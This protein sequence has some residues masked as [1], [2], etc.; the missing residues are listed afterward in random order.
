MAS[1]VA[2][3]ISNPVIE[4]SKWSKFV[5]KNGVEICALPARH[6]GG[7]FVLPVRY[8]NC[9]GYAITQGG[10][11]LVYTGDSGYQDLY[12]DVG[13]KF[14]VGLAI[15]DSSV[16][17]RNWYSQMRHMDVNQAI[18]CW[19]DLKRPHFIPFHFGTFF[20]GKERDD[21]IRKTW[22]KKVLMNPLLE[23]KIHILASGQSF[24]RA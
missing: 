16:A 15:I 23:E 10:E 17:T 9:H 14:N 6:P 18:Q 5:L 19:E 13:N 3:L 11:S 2:H 7:R 12:E 22:Q 21:K 24:S 1:A 20:G 4:L 8:R